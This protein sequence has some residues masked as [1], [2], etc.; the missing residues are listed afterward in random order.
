MIHY[1]DD[2]FI[3]SVMVKSLDAC[4]SSEADPEL[5]GD[6]IM[7][8]IAFADGCSRRFYALLGQNP[9]LIERAEYLK[10]LERTVRSFAAVLEGLIAGSYPRASDYSSYRQQLEA[11]L[12][13]AKG[14]L[15]ELA[16]L[17]SS[18]AEGG[19]VNE[20][21]SQDELSELLRE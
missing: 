21:V 13:E 16:P 20:V 15:A 5:F 7:G 14:L 10:L 2:L 1:Q 17:V 18:S 8:D 11:T 3:L 9:L 6:R 12:R 4:L 19:S